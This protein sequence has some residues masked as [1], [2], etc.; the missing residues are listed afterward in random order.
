M[1]WIYL[2]IEG[3]NGFEILKRASGKIGRGG[4]MHLYFHLKKQKSLKKYG[5]F[6]FDAQIKEMCTN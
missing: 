4:T 6:K 2:D 5:R 3:L 1:Q